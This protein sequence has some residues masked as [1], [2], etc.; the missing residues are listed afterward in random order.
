MGIRYYGWEL[1]D[2]EIAEARLDPW[3]VIRT[4]DK[5]EGPD[6]RN[7][8]LDKAWTLLQRALGGQSFGSAGPQLAR[9][10]FALIDG[11][12]T[13]PQGYQHGY[14]PHIGMLTSAQLRHAE[15][16]LCRVTPFDLRGACIRRDDFDYARHYLLE[17]QEFAADAVSRGHGVIY[18]IG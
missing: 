7:T 12:V 15:R 16:D 11:D 9:P 18:E 5:R 3:P 6:W 1:A 4:A 2:L 14:L 13:Y 10:A 17:L 8:C